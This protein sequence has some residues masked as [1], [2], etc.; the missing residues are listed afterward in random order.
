MITSKARGIL[1][2]FFGLALTG[3]S[4]Q[5]QLTQSLQSSVDSNSQLIGAQQNLL[6]YQTEKLEDLNATQVAIADTLLAL[7]QQL[8]SI[9]DL[10]RPVDNAKAPKKRKKLPVVAQGNTLLTS[11]GVTKVIVGRNEWVWLDL[12]N[13]PL[14]S[15]IDTGSRSSSLSAENIQ[16]FE[17]NGKKW[18]RFSLPGETDGKTYESPLVSHIRIRNASSEELERRPVVSLTVRMGDIVEDTEFSLS[19]RENM[20]YPVLLGRDFLR[21][22]AVVDVAK[23]FTQP[24]LDA[25]TVSR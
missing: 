23:K 1:W 11:E 7:R 6:E 25:Q 15:R 16:P 5:P 3:C 21:D 17:R 9:Q 8:L 2:L 24:K 10:S 19:S 20:L 12:L 13:Q 4:M 22:I 14:K 18:V